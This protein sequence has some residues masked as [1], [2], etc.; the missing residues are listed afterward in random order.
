R[1]GKLT[2]PVGV[3]ARLSV[4]DPDLR[5]VLAVGLAHVKYVGSA[6]ACD[7]R[8]LFF[9]VVGVARLASDYGSEDHDS[10]LTLPDEAAEFIPGAKTCDVAGVGLLRSDQQDIMQAVAMESPDGRE[11]RGERL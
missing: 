5:H 2:E 3:F 1:G 10:F 8:R 6:E 11:V 4:H 9:I 7:T